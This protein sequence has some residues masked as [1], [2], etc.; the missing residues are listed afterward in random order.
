MKNATV[1]TEESLAKKPSARNAVV[2]MEVVE[3]QIS[4]CPISNSKL[5]R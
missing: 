4:Y 3:L 5:L 1:V 2:D